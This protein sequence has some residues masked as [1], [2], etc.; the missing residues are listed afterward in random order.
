MTLLLDTHTFLWFCQDDPLLSA[1]AKVLIE[2]P[3]NRCPSGESRQAPEAAL[4]GGWT[5]GYPEGVSI[6]SP[7]RQAVPKSGPFFAGHLPGG[8]LYLMS[9]VTRILNAIEH[10]DPNAA[11]QLLPLLYNELRSLAAHKMA[12]EAAG[13]TLQGGSL[14]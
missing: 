8:I 3:G 5:I 14:E 10:G 11:G 1:S 4:A 9:E 12:Q 13:Q 2:D 6:L 7:R